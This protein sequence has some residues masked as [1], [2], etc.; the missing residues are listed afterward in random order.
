MEEFGI[1]DELGFKF[2]VGAGFDRLFGLRGGLGCGRGFGSSSGLRRR[3][4]GAA[5]WFRFGNFH[6]QLIEE[7][8]AVGFD[9]DAIGGFELGEDFLTAFARGDVSFALRH[10]FGIEQAVVIGSEGFG[11]NAVVPRSGVGRTEA[12]G[13]RFFEILVAIVKRHTGLLN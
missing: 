11:V 12:A 4:F 8:V 5:R 3:L 7:Q 2:D 6:D 9:R 10:F 1:E 13:E